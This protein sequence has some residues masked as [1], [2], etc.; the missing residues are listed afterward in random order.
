M[1]VDITIAQT[2]DDVSDAAP[3]MRALIAWDLGEFAKV[4]GMDLNPD[5]YLANSM[6]H[7]DDYMPPE[8]RFLMARNEA[9]ALVGML[10]LHELRDGVGEVKRLYV[11]PGTRG[12]GLGQRLVTRLVEEARGIGYQTLVLD[13]G[14]YMNAAHRIYK[15]AEFVE[16]D[17][18]EGGENDGDVAKHLIFMAL[19]LGGRP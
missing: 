4:S 7:L 16:T 1:S 9:G 11:D 15:A 5:D 3:L 13:T 10:L 14:S 6:D 2:P 8:G 12:L 18:Y 19:N 17:P